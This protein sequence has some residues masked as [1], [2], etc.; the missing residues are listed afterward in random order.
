MPRRVKRRYLALKVTSEQ[1]IRERD[2][3]GVVWDAVLRLFGEYGASRV[4]LTLIEYDPERKYAI[5][6]CSH[7]SVEML[8]ASIA[9]VT[10]IDGKPAAIHII[11]VSG[12]LRSLRR[13]L[14]SL[15]KKAGT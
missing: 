8:R 14:R 7:R 6:R 4:D 12:T 10:D 1:P 15:P 3:G 11:G 13:N 5:M 2:L 9:A